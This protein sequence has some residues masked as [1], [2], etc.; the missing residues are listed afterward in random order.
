MDK[1]DAT[2]PS[3]EI[4]RDGV[5]GPATEDELKT[6]IERMGLYSD[7]KGACSHVMSQMMG[8]IERLR[9]QLDAHRSQDIARYINWEKE[10]VSDA[11]IEAIRARWGCDEMDE[12]LERHMNEDRPKPGSDAATNTIMNGGPNWWVD[13]LSAYWGGD[14]APSLT[15]RRAAKTALR[16]IKEMDAA[17]TNIAGGDG[18]PSITAKLTL[19]A[20][21]NG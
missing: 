19:E 7:S 5:W 8:E 9:R 17:L 2:G 15:T 4:M 16:V 21:A 14:I 3:W 1:P 12:E 20:I 6:F 13:E 10:P 18:D 11:R